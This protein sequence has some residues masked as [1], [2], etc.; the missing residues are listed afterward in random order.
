MVGHRKVVGVGEFAVVVDGAINWQAVGAAEV[1][2]VHA[3]TGSDV[4]E[5]GA[6][7]VFDKVVAGEKLGGF[8]NERMAVFKRADFVAVERLNFLDV[9][10]AARF[11]DGRQ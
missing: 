7:A 11:G 8:V 9:F 2:I 4:D 1:V 3:V 5:T 10:P 6:G